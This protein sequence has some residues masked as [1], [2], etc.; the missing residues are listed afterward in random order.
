MATNNAI[1]NSSKVTTYTSSDTWTKDTRTKWVEIYAISG[2][3]GGGSGRK[4]TST[5]A[6]GGG[7]GNGGNGFYWT[8]PANFFGNSETV[9]IGGTA[10]GGIAQTTDATNGNPG[11]ANNVTSFGDLDTNSG[12]GA[13]GGTTGSVS[14]GTGSNSFSN[15]T[16]NAGLSGP[17]GRAT[18]G[19]NGGSLTLANATFYFIGSAGGGGAGADAVT[20]R[21]GG[22]GGSVLDRSIATI[23]SP[24]AGGLESTGI[25]G[26]NGNISVITG[27]LMT[28]GTGGGG[29]GGYS[30]GAGGATAG[31][32]GGNGGIPGGGGGGGGGGIDA[33]ANSGAGGSGAR[34]QIIVIEYF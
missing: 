16:L 23:I 3:G 6:G 33:V 30:V 2:G 12:A 10:N 1:N 28:G 21:V 7:G 25:N 5:A 8:A 4:G 34:G 15:L 22:N 31:G 32:N 11:T 9:T 26:G 27:G 17:Q 14:G 19:S 29:G 13:A 24:G 18:T 20:E